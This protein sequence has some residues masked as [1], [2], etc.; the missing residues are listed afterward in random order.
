MHHECPGAQAGDVDPR[1]QP[2]ALQLLAD[3]GVL[4][5]QLHTRR[6]SDR[7]EDLQLDLLR[8]LPVWRELQQLIE[9][10]RA[11]RPATR[12]LST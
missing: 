3:L 5:H 12:R 11:L 8:I 7:S 9:A 4:V 1:Q 6:T 10:R 2:L